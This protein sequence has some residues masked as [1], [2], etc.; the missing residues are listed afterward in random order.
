MNKHDAAVKGLVILHWRAES[1]L[2]ADFEP[3]DLYDL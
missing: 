2:S 1:S 3:I